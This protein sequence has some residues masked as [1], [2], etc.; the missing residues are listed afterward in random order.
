VADLVRQGIAVWFIDHGSTDGTVAAVEPLLGRGVLQIEHLAGTAAREPG[1][2]SWEAVLRRKEELAR[3]IDAGWFIHQDAD[4]FRESPWPHLDLVQAIALVE[5]SGHDAID[6]ALL[7]FWPTHDRF[8]AGEDPRAAFL[9]YTPGAA[10]DR[11]QIR[12]WRK[13]AGP[14]DLVS[15]GGHE[16]RFPGRRVFPIRFLLR[17]YPYRSRAQAERKVQ[18]DRRARFPLAEQERGWHRQYVDVP[19]LPRDPADLTPFDADQVRLA[20]FLEHRGVEDLRQSPVAVDRAVAEARIAA[21]DARRELDARNHEVE[22]QARDLDARNLR[23]DALAAD[24]HA[25]N[26]EI[27]RL[28]AE[29]HDRNVESARLGAELHERNLE[30]GRLA[31]D[32]HSRNVEIDRLAGELHARNLEIGRLTGELHSRN[33]A[34]ER[35]AAD[36]AALGDQLDDV[37]QQHDALLGRSETLAREHDAMAARLRAGETELAEQRQGAQ[38]LA[39]RVAAMEQ[40]RI[41]RWSAPLRAWLDRLAR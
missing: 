33:V 25:R 21:E 20:L 32:L 5:R 36:L 8:R 30:S 28:S 23:I 10:Y 16:A 18:R 15:S 24:L 41:W 37:R 6:F 22:R 29:L 2:A 26:L 35:L 19:A 17:H 40:S 3:E 7:D 34:A 1:R 39:R 12:C 31:A 11:V 14:V 9:H 13:Q 4:E 38:A 27:E